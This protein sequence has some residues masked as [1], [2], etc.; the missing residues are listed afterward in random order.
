[1]EMK[2]KLF[3]FLKRPMKKPT[4][5]ILIAHRELRGVVKNSI[6]CPIQTGCANATTLLPD[7]LRD[8][9]GEN[10]SLRNPSYNELSAHYW[11][12]KNQDKLDNPD[13]IGLMHNR[14]H[15]I[16][17]KNLQIPSV[18][19]TWLP[20]SNVYLYPFMTKDYALHVSEDKIM[21]YFP[22]YDCMVLKPYYEVLPVKGKKLTKGFGYKYP[23]IFDVFVQVI[24]EKFP[25]YQEE[26]DLFLKEDKQYLCN[27]FVM[28]KELF[29]EYSSFLFGILQEVDLRID[30]SKFTGLKLRF[31][32][33][34]GEF[35]LSIFM[36]KIHKDPT[37]K[38]IEVNGAFFYE[39]LKKNDI[40][41]LFRY[42]IMSFLCIG[43][44]RKSY[45][46]KFKILN[47]KRI[48]QKDFHY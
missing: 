41:N 7:M 12:W 47:Q 48:L 36:T 45:Q 17:D 30:S 14:R 21:S 2:K 29:E 24:R 38:I 26:L 23:E 42:K 28:K 27:M 6:L 13:Y 35:L 18:D 3:F 15:F 37:I 25:D 31:L 32:G 40:I 5:K 8:N 34:L 46:E 9:E 22:K 1:M 20:K 19:F 43:K 39:L 33:Y 11:A 44:K 4:V 10:V 16:F